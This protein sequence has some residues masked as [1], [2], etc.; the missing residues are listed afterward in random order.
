MRNDSFV[1]LMFA[2]LMTG[3]YAS[4]QTVRVNWQTK[5]AF[6]DYKTYAWK[7]VEKRP[8]GF[9]KQWVVSD[10][11]ATLTKKGLKKVDAR[12][13]PDIYIT[14]NFL[15][16][17]IMDSSTT[18]DGFGWDDG[19]WGYRGGWGGWDDGTDDAVSTT[20]TQPRMMGILTVD[21]ADAR[22]A[23]VIWRGQATEDAVSNKQRGDEQQI[24]KSV[25]KMF[26]NYPPK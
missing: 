2:L 21:M 11:D 19:G 8:A 18:T 3:P 20:E 5:A 22:K 24:Q 4:S 13:K 17:E 6:S 7:F 12:Q 23:R 26:K 15:T 16:Q 10:V 1:Y 9:Y 25:E 14:Y